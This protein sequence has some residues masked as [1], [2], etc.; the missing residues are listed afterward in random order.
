MKLK[1]TYIGSDDFR[2]LVVY[3]DDFVDKTQFIKDIIEDSG[4]VCL[5]TRPRRWGKS[6]NMNMLKTFLEIQ[7]D[8]L[9]NVIESTNRNLFLGGKVELNKCK[10]IN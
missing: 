6:V 8:R 4:Y 1:P 3:N 5:I 7:V 10:F 2:S 9:G